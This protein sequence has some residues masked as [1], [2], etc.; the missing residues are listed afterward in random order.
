MKTI[1]HRLFSDESRELEIPEELDSKASEFVKRITES[2]AISLV[3][4]VMDYPYLVNERIFDDS[5]K[6]NKGKADDE[7][8]LSLLKDSVYLETC[9]YLQFNGFNFDD[10]YK[11]IGEIDKEIVPM[12][13]ALRSIYDKRKGIESGR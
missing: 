7:N 8:E 2:R 3:Q 10:I 5:I 12:V 11:K 13:D 4:R 6:L 9:L 1:K